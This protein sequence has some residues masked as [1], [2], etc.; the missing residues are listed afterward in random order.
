MAADSTPTAPTAALTRL[1]RRREVAEIAGL[2]ERT[3]ER[4]D[5][6]GRGPTQTRIGRNVRYHPS[7]VQRWLEER[8]QR[9]RHAA[10]NP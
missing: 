8:R 5:L 4:L 7:D 10:I 3:I 9:G 1:L 6:E 2:C